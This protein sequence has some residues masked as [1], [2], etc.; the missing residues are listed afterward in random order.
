MLVLSLDD[1]TLSRAQLHRLTHSDRSMF[2][3]GSDS[4]WKSWF[5]ELHAAGFHLS[6]GLG[7]QEQVTIG[8][9]ADN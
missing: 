5:A 8:V 3:I 9:F 2:N 4:N 6:I 1:M 7:D